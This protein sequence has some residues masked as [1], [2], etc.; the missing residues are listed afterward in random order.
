[1]VA[2]FCLLIMGFLVSFVVSVFVGFFSYPQKIIP[3][4]HC[5]YALHCKNLFLCKNLLCFFKMMS[6]RVKSVG[7]S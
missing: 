4:K 5:I 2:W 6:T 7:F 1:M 3:E